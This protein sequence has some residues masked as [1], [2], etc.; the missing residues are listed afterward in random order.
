M[1]GQT[2]CNLSCEHSIRGKKV[3][4]F[5]SS[6]KAFLHLVKRTEWFGTGPNGLKRKDN[7][8]LDE[9]N[10]IFQQKIHFWFIGCVTF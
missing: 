6:G 1:Q 4:E 10:C 5:S 3:A 2:P 8:K 9:S 7:D